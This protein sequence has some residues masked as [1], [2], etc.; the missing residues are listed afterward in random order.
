KRKGNSVDERFIDDIALVDSL[1]SPEVREIYE[2]VL[3]RHWRA[4]DVKE[5]EVNTWNQVYG[6]AGVY[7]EY[8]QDFPAFDALPEELARKAIAL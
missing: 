8:R 1:F 6:R 4:L 5:S 2:D 3:R 7:L